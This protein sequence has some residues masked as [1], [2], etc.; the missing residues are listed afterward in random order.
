MNL[1]LENRVCA[2]TGASSGIGFEVTRQLCSEGAK[3]LMISR[4][5]EQLAAM[6]EVVRAEGGTA[7]VLVMD[8]TEDHAG[9]HVVA[10]ARQ[11][12]GGLDVLVNNA[13]ASKWRDL[14]DAPEQ[15]FRDQLELSVMA[16]LNLM[17]AALPGMLERGWG[18]IVNVSSTAGKRPSAMMPDYSVG[19]AAM[20]SLSRLFADRYAADGVL[21]NAVCPGPTG[22]ELWMEPGGLL[23]QAKHESGADS[24]KEAE[25]AVGAKRPIG[26]LATPE[27][28]ASVITFLCSDRASYVSGAAWGVD[29]G[30][31]P[32]IT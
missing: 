28:I 12:F 7:G 8:I 13:G 16:P 17:R 20:L 1:G 21:V 14:E 5:P 29:G 32:V 15:D 9:E 31:V 27:E 24:R 18:R 11:E 25:Q 6:S 26:R 4:N 22:S 19:K 23:D 30:T 2:V 10:A 3:V